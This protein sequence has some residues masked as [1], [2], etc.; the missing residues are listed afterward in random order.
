[1][2]GQTLRGFTPEQRGSALAE[3]PLDSQKREAAAIG[4]LGWINKQFPLKDFRVLKEHREELL[5]SG[6][7]SCPGV[8]KQQQ[9]QLKLVQD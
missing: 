1:M 5:H 6:C 9:L 8:Q 7:C 4:S 3:V 2:Q